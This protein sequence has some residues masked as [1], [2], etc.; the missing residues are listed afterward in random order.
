MISIS[1][2]KTLANTEHSSKRWLWL[3]SYPMRI[4]EFSKESTNI[5]LSGRNGSGGRYNQPITQIYIH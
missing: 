5:Q 3:V 2:V 4:T 1:R